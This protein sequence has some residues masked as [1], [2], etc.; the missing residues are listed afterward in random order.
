MGLLA[1][2]GGGSWNDAL[3]PVQIDGGELAADLGCGACHAGLPTPDRARERAPTLGNAGPPIPT[4]FVFT[5]LAAPERRR[6]NIGLTRMPDFSLDEA[7]RVALAL[8]LGTGRPSGGTAQAS[9]RHPDADAELGERLFA[10]LGCAGCHSGVGETAPG[11]VGPDLSREG[12]RARHEWLRSF[13]EAPTAIR[14]DGH[15]GSPG[16]RMPDFHLSDEEAEALGTFLGGLG[17]RFAELDTVS[18]T[19]FQTLRTRRLLEDRLACLGCHE[20]G[21]EG[22]RIGP[23]LDGLVERREES[24]VLEMILDPNQAVPGSP[25]PRQAMPERDARRLARYLLAPD[26]LRAPRPRVS[27]ASSSHPAWVEEEPDGTSEGAALYARYCA[28][29][30]GPEGWGDGWNASRLPVRPTAHADSARMARRADDTLFDAISGGAWVL[31]GSPRMPPFG[32]LLTTGQIRALVS[33]IRVLCS[34]EGPDWS[35]DGRRAPPIS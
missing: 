28:S 30:H 16:A 9:A 8:F 4:D 6:D 33:Y 2:W 1:A 11:R 31:G 34:C 19:P 32:G 14:R 25:M 35:R 22:G 26:S 24:F 10:L 18:L 15:P 7:E 20:V 3:R 29:C 27:L 12:V 21:G 17:S 5:Y 23:P 13:L